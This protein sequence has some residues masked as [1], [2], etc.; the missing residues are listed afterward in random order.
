METKEYSRL[1]QCLICRNDYESCPHYEHEPGN[2]C[3]YYALPIDN[4]QFMGHFFSTV[5][6]IR[7]LEYTI[8]AIIAHVLWIVFL[9]GIMLL[10][11]SYT[12]RGWQDIDFGINLILSCIAA[13]P[14]GALLVV[15]GIKRCHDLGV[16]NWYAWIPAISLIAVNVPFLGFFWIISIVYLVFQKGEEGINKHGSEPGRPYRE[17]L[18]EAQG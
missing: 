1:N 6:R 16:N 7:R 12:H 15:A 11:V 2:P 5:G 8:T 10:Y 17:Q 18:R 3:V 4:S 9:C 13:L 14:A